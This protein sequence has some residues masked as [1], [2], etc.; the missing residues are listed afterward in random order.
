M[1]NIDIALALT[2]GIFVNDTL[3]HEVESEINPWCYLKVVSVDDA[4]IESITMPDFENADVLVGVNLPS[5]YV[6]N[7]AITKIKMSSGDVQ[8][9]KTRK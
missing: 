2:G 6:I 7:G 9:V 5:S 3:E 4:V 8:L 1:R